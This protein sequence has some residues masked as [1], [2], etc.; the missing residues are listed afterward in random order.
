MPC[1]CDLKREK[2]VA[3][4]AGRY[5]IMCVVL[6]AGQSAWATIGGKSGIRN[7]SIQPIIVKPSI[8]VMDE[9]LFV[10]SSTK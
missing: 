9:C 1:L 3:Y 6:Y 2:S 7:A 10:V 5:S 4:I 8:L